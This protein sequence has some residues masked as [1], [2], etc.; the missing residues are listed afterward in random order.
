MQRHSH[1]IQ[2]QAEFALSTLETLPP[3]AVTGY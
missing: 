3:V 1:Y 2:E